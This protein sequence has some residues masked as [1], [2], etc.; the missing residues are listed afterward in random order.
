MKKTVLVSLFVFISFLANAQNWKSHHKK[1]YSPT[2]SCLVW[3]D[4]TKKFY[5][6][7]CSEIG[8]GGSVTDTTKEYRIAQGRGSTPFLL[9]FNGTAWVKNDTSYVPQ[10]GTNK[11]CC[12][13]DSSYP[14]TSFDYSPI[15]RC[16]RCS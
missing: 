16:S 4:S 11:F 7:K 15:R 2:D 8:G 6:V 13:S 14:K 1:P 5:R 3:Q 10:S 12:G 9:Y